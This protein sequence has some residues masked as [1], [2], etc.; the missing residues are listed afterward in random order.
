MKAIQVQ[1]Y[2]GTD[3]ITINNDAQKPSIQPGKVLV[4]VHSASLNRIDS[5]IRNGYMKDMLHLQ[6]PISLGGDFS[7]VVSEI[8][9]GVTSFKP[10]DEVY[11]N[12]GHFKGGTGSLADFT[13]A[14]AENIALKPTTI[15]FTQA[16]SLPLVA[17]SALQGIEE[18]IQLKAGQKILIQGG[19]GGI[20]SLAIQIAKLAGAYV[21]ASVST[22]DV[23]FVKSL[24][25][26]QV[27][28]YKTRDVTKELQEFDAVFDT[29]G[30]EA[31]DQLFAVL[32]K[33]SILVT[34]AGQPKQELAEQF[35]VTAR[36]QMTKANTAQ[37]NRVAELVDSG[38]LKVQVE[39]IFSFTEGKEAF[40][41]FETQHPRGKV[42]INVK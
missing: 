34:M 16:A 26:D 22:D 2:G 3:V 37:L 7:G 25:A 41:Y 21:A 18:E 24:G 28:D 27:I 35:G 14:N 5:A 20:G 10:G 19:A 1:T 29:A 4:V 9:E 8:G 36:S 42:V 30:G 23:D 39:K 15:D 6:L 31:M 11:G 32:K 40:T 17:A 33:G 38:K 13:E 12:A